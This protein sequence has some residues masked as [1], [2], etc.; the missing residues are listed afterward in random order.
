MTRL[1]VSDYLQEGDNA[2]TNDWECVYDLCATCR[3]T[4]WRVDL[5]AHWSPTKRVVVFGNSW[6]GVPLMPSKKEP[7][8][9][10]I[11]DWV[12]KHHDANPYLRHLAAARARRDAWE[13]RMAETEKKLKKDGANYA[14]VA[15]D[16]AAPKLALV[17]AGVH[18]RMKFLQTRMSAVRHTGIIRLFVGPSNKAHHEFDKMR[19]NLPKRGRGIRLMAW[20]DGETYFGQDVLDSYSALNTNLLQY[21]KLPDRANSAIVDKVLALPEDLDSRVDSA[22]RVY[23]DCE[24]NSADKL[25]LVLMPYL[26]SVMEENVFKVMN[27]LLDATKP[28]EDSTEFWQWWNAGFNCLSNRDRMMYKPDTHNDIATL[29]RE[30]AIRKMRQ[31]RPGRREYTDF[32][33]EK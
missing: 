7:T 21:P 15:W 11:I 1:F 27:K 33:V 30:V 6:D 4:Y 20:F 26:I 8:E 28:G 25:D 16:F 10:Q 24:Y 3:L 13:R 12:E 14:V 2:L 9:R 23:V 31:Y 5:T 32:P 22:M 18:D 29:A 17:P 19:R